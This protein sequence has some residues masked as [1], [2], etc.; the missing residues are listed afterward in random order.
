MAPPLEPGNGPAPGPEDG[1]EQLK[2]IFYQ[3]SELPASERAAFLDEACAGQPDQRAEIEALLEYVDEDLPEPAAMKVLEPGVVLGGRF[4]LIRMVGEG[5]MGQ[6][7]EARDLQL[8]DDGSSSV[9]VALK[10]IRPELSGTPGI[11]TQFRRELMLSRKIG[12]R[13][14]CRMFDIGTHRDTDGEPILFLSMEFLDGEPLAARLR[15]NQPPMDRQTVYALALQLFAGLREVHRAGIVHR[16]LTPSNLHLVAEGNGFRVVMTDFGLA[17]SLTPLQP[18]VT[19]VL[20][21]TPGYTAPEQL[22][23]GDYSVQADVYSLGVILYEMAAGARYDPVNARTVLTAKAP[24]WAPTILRCLERD[25]AKRPQTVDEVEA[26]FRPPKRFFVT[27]GIAAK[28]A[29]VAAAVGLAAAAMQ[30]IQR[31]PETVSPQFNRVTF[32]R[33]LASEPSVTADGRYMVYASDRTADDVSVIW[34]RELPGGQTIQLT[35]DDAHATNPAISPDGRLVAYRSGRKGGGVYVVPAAG[36]EERLIGPAGRHPMFSPDGKSIVYWTGQD[37]DVTTPTGRIWRYETDSQTVNQLHPEF[38]DAR[39]PVWSPDGTHI[40]FRGS[41]EGTAGWNERA[42]WWVS[43]GRST[44]EATGAFAALRN[45]GISIHDSRIYWDK[46]RVLFGGRAAH[47]TN[48]WSLPV[49]G[50]LAKTDGVPR[51]LTAGTESVST[52]WPLPDGTIAYSHWKAL[53][54]ISR[55]PLRNGKP[56]PIEPVS[57]D[58]ALDTRVN[59]SADGKRLMFT[60]RLGEVRNV[61]VLNRESGHQTQLLE[62]KPAI[63]FLSPDGNQI[64]YSMPMQAKNPIF[65]TGADGSGNRTLCEDCGEVAGWDGTGRY[66]LFLTATTTSARGLEAI[67]VN[68]NRRR[69]LLAPAAGLSEAS[70]SSRG[71]L[72]FAVR[73]EGTKS[74]LYVAPMAE[75]GPSPRSTWIAALPDAMYWSDKPRW[76]PDGSTLYYLTD[77]DGFTNVRRIGMGLNGL[78]PGTIET[79]YVGRSGRAAPHHL[80][81]PA[82]G[83]GVAEDSVVI[84]LPDLTGNIWLLRTREPRTFSF[85]SLFRN[86]LPGQQN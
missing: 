30:L 35:K 82:H 77:Q 23:R 58:D 31:D 79:V 38:A 67:E 10:V 69:V 2:D 17:R 85:S 61:W 52:P 18:G 47:A 43:D 21:G 50:P 41:R 26:A 19:R 16:D 53:I 84:N 25:P 1:R 64:A 65:L 54:H 51:P 27:K 56:G 74:Q 6:V 66:V 32:D 45:A 8:S 28:A 80:S 46:N 57:L 78:Q 40:L 7:Y 71:V 62:D 63:P 33:G 37:G 5:G 55:I 11:E 72:A 14:V 68:S 75:D 24:E 9:R 3:A 76:S 29:A 4:E 81:R 83:M 86:L 70:L 73:S 36:G 59:I 13:N 49:S 48:L 42:D 20:A 22:E 39:F 60:R 34:R 15:A 12:H 44:P